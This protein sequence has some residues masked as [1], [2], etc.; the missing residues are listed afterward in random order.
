MLLAMVRPE[1]SLE[2]HCNEVHHEKSPMHGVGGTV[3]N[4]VYCRVLA[5]DA[6]IGNPKKFANF[7][8]SVCNVDSLLL[9]MN[10]LFKSQSK[11]STLSP[12]PIHC[13][14]TK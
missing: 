11:S 6:V 4:M 13:K 2:W 3:K 12:S 1:L 14:R 9:R 7:A 10:A 8:Q 5:G